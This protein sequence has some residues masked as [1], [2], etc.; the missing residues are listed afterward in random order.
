MIEKSYNPLFD[1]FL[2]PLIHTTRQF[3]L[4]KTKIILKFFKDVDINF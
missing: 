1:R 4:G 2:N 3:V